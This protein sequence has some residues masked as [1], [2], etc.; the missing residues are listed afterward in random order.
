MSRPAKMS[1]AKSGITRPSVIFRSGPVIVERPRHAH[2]NAF[3]PGDTRHRASRRIAWTR[4]SR[5]AVR[6]TTRCRG[7]FRAS[8]LPWPSGRRRSRSTNRTGS[9]AA[10]APAVALRHCVI[11]QVAQAVDVGVD[12]LERVRA[13]IGRRRDARRVDDVIEVPHV[14][15]QRLDHVDTAQLEVRAPAQRFEPL[16]HAAHVIVVHRDPDPGSRPR[17]CRSSAARTAR[18]STRETRR[19]PSPAGARPPF[20]RTPRPD[21]RT[22]RPDPRPG[23]AASQSFVCVSAFPAT[24]VWV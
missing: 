18:G 15:R 8:E 21:P 1:L 9:P 23:A 14:I 12:A 20:H 22:P 4:R 3:L 16:R 13:I 10:G 2:R 7:R 17:A 6:C 24:P 19:P 5:R 11:E